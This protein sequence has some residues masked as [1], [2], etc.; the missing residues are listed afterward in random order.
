[1]VIDEFDGLM[2]RD[3]EALYLLPSCVA[4]TWNL[5]SLM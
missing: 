4:E 2:G 5:V 1:M 3:N